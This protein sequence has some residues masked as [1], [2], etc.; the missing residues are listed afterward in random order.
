MKGE[1]VIISVYRHASEKKILAVIGHIG[2]EHV[3]Q[4]LDLVFDLPK[5]GLSGLTAASDLMTAPDPDYE[6]LEKAMQKHKVPRVR[7]PL[8]LGEFGTKVIAVENNVLKF[9]LPFH[10]FALVELSE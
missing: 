6:W 2:K 7:A 5:L 8:R 1:N 9:H 3:N 4:D 10:S